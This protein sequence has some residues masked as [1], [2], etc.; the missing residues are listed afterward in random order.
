MG[1][2]STLDLAR[3]LLASGR[4]DE[5]ESL[6]RDV[7]RARPG[8]VEALEGLGV[9]KFQ[10]GR[11]D[12]AMTLLAQAAAL[13]PDS[14]R[15][16]AHLSEALRVL[17]RYDEAAGEVQRALAL[18]P[19]AA[20]CWNALGLL[21]HDQKRYDDAL[22][23]YREA[24]T[25]QPHFVP[26]HVNLGM[27]LMELRRPGEAVEALRAAVRIEPDD[28]AA[29]VN[30]GQALCGLRAPGLLEEAEAHLRRA[31]ALAP[32]A[33]GVLEML[34]HV[35]HLQGR[36]GEALTCYEQAL[37]LAPRRASLR[38]SMGE[39]LQASGRHDDAQRVLEAAV[40]LDPNDARLRAQLGSLALARHRFE[41]AH[42]HYRAAL[43]LD[44]ASAE[45]HCGL[46]LALREQGRFDEAESCFR[47]AMRLDPS[48]TAPWV[49]LA[50]LQ[51]ERG[52]RSESC[53]TARRILVA[54]PDLADAYWRLAIN[55]KE[56]LP[57]RDL[58]TMEGLLER[59]ELSHGERAALHFGAGTVLD[60]RGLHE[61]A[62]GHFEA[63]NALQAAARA[64][65]GQS[66]DPDGHS[67]SIDQ[68][69]AAFTPALVA[70][71]RDW[72]D[73]DP[74]PV[75]VVGLPRSGTSLVEQ[76]LASHPLVHG[77]GELPDVL[78]LFNAMPNLVGQPGRNAFD[79]LRSLGPDP[80]RAAARRYLARLDRLAP[81]TARRIVDKMPD[82]F[83]LLG[84]IALLWPGARVLLC[85]RDLRDI[86]VSCWQSSFDTIPWS[87]DWEHMARRFADHERLLAHWERTRPMA[88]L[89]VIYE[90]LVSDPEGQSRRL[91][92]FLGLEWEPACLEFYKARR[93]VR[94]A[95][96]IQ[97]REPIHTRSV[98]RWRRYEP[99][100]R[101]FLEAL[102]RSGV[103][104]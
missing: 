54:R 81:A 96:Q 37:E 98:G 53:E 46:G 43:S 1:S 64:A 61:R 99:T 29:L 41:D 68:V 86:A 18:D 2:D 70:R 88:W 83:P 5:A 79:A 42:A 22:A 33:P 95:S 32:R 102:R 34:G 60:A 93:V 57:D 76:V 14:A 73:P 11:A 6:Y 80:A 49:E 48:L 10:R 13:A 82:N 19:H 59:K 35:L 55:L 56:A 91:I 66:F 8:E 94:T 26:A 39:L 52:D 23:A 100:L 101:P 31:L 103:V 47:E 28:L 89:D 17:G 20:P 72:G 16:H 90:E 44:G 77:V 38:R 71:G 92:A 21:A 45:A 97:V 40:A 85:R 7:L 67:R 69:I 62:A 84:F 9:L 78:G 87:N 36:S 3:S 58:R 24:I 27:L 75:F 65:K 25:R 51:A 15:L 12:E 30:L 104:V 4:L 74:R 50:R 63:A